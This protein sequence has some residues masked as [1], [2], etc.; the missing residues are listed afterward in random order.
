MGLLADYNLPFAAALVFMALLALAQ[1]LGI[2]GFEIDADAEPDLDSP[3]ALGPVDGLL[4]IIGVRRLPFAMWLALFLL[5][6]AALGVSAQ[7]LAIQLVGEPLDVVLAAALAGAAG[8]PTTGLLARPLAMILPKDETSVVSTD[9]LV[10]RRA[11]ISVGRAAAGSP[12]R[13]IV[14]DRFGQM[15]NVMVEPHDSSGLL[16]EGD[17][18]LLVRRDGETFFAIGLEDHRLA[19]IG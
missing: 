17:T 8:L 15:H 16:L 7:S 6:F 18:V 9:A 10:G 1:G 13:A 11:T 12:A 14:Y 5:I 4:S 2:G 19:P 3:G